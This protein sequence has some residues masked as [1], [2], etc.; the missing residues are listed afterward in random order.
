MEGWGLARPALLPPP[1]PPPPPYLTPARRPFPPSPERRGRGHCRQHAPTPSPAH[2]GLLAALGYGAT[3]PS[4]CPLSSPSRSPLQSPP[5]RPAIMASAAAT[6]TLTTAAN[7]SPTLRSP[8][9]PPPGGALC[10]PPG[11]HRP[12]RPGTAPLARPALRRPPAPRWEGSPGGHDSTPS[13]TTSWALRASTAGKCKVWFVCRVCACMWC[14]CVR[15]SVCEWARNMKLATWNIRTPLDSSGRT[16][17]PD[18][19]TVLV[20]S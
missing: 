18:E 14:I 4:P 7:L 13:R 5:H 2:P 10:P 6:S 9:T 16:D 12:T 20:C 3:P 8:P 17:R 19:R 11:A 1:P 15:M